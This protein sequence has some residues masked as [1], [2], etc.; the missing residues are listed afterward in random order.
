MKTSG[1][2]LL[3][4]LVV[5][6][7]FSASTVLFAQSKPFGNEDPQPINDSVYK[8]Q[9]G[10]TLWQ[11]AGDQLDDPLKWGKIL[12]ANPFLDEPG[13]VF[14]K[15]GKIIVLIKPG[16]ELVIPDGLGIKLISVPL[17][18][19]QVVAPPAAVEE[20]ALRK[21]AALPWW[22]YVA[23]MALAVFAAYWY[24]RHRLSNPIASGPAV[25]PGGIRPDEG[26]RLRQEF[27]RMAAANF[28]DRTGVTGH[29]LES[30]SIEEVAT[31]RFSGPWMIGYRG[32]S[33]QLKRMNG[34]AGYRARVRFPDNHEETLYSLQ[35][36]FNPARMGERMFTRGG[37]FEEGEAVNT[38]PRPE[39]IR[40]R[41]EQPAF[42]PTAGE[43]SPTET[44]ST[45]F[46]V[47][48]HEIV[49]PAG[50]EV[51]TDGSRLII[52]PPV[53]STAPIMV[54]FAVPRKRKRAV[55]EKPAQHVSLARPAG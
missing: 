48:G 26:N 20:S 4:V 51:R 44:N 46:N 52:Q 9:P 40:R 5:L 39:P 34:E 10:D 24:I 22:A 45:T 32:Q 1:K 13:R 21:I 6:A 23:F 49:V 42:R 11:L 43:A 33:P 36:C 55:V 28:A 35:A 29:S 7:A 53:D 16:E 47:G 37:R 8:V 38:A 19:L 12:G 25:I 15:D 2:L 50:T 54:T 18:E 17:S 31:G 27:Q 3:L 14:E 30:F 41:D